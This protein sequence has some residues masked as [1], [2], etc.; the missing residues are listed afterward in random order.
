MIKLVEKPVPWPNGARVA[1]AVTFDVDVDSILHL[2]FPDTS[3]RMAATLSLLR[4]ERIAVKRIVDMFRSFD[5][6][7]TF[8]IPAWCMERYPE[9]VDIILEGGHEIGHHGYIHESPNSFSR[10]DERYWL[11]KGIDVIE[12]MTGARPRGWRAPL[13]HFSEHSTDLLIEEGFLYDASLMG[14]DLP[15]L[16]RS[17]K[18]EIIEIPS[19]WALDDWGQ[20]AEVDELGYQS[21][22]KAPDEAMAV[23]MAEFEAAWKYQTSWVSVWHPMVSGRLARCDRIVTMIEQMLNKGDVWFATMEQIANHI[24]KCIEDGSY[25]PGIERM[26]AYD[27]PLPRSTFEPVKQ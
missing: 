26:P 24:K 1:V 21:P 14:D 13:Y 12:R 25:L 17:A 9:L 3:H 2:A 15:Y 10:E 11:Q 7:Q 8:F 16:L 20:Y 6:R 19:Y 23:F 5:I 18:G 22:M 4:Y 27:G